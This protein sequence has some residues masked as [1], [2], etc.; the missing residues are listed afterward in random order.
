MLR[1]YT[2]QEQSSSI[3]H[4]PGLTPSPVSP[5]STMEVTRPK[6]NPKPWTMND[7]NRIIF[8]YLLRRVSGVVEKVRNNYRGMTN[9]IWDD[10][11]APRW[12]YCNISEAEAS[13]QIEILAQSRICEEHRPALIERYEWLERY[14]NQVANDWSRLVA[15]YTL[16][17]EWMRVIEV[18][19]DITRM[20]RRIELPRKLKPPKLPRPGHPSQDLRHSQQSLDRGCASARHATEDIEDPTEID[21]DSSVQVHDSTSAASNTISD[22][23]SDLTMTFPMKWI[24]MKMTPTKMTKMARWRR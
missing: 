9:R 14:T 15:M 12:Q 19:G 24:L 16:E 4:L 20:M 22:S 11:K 10:V 5:I 23:D 6:K 1:A 13:K 8:M 18:F 17:Q 2:H 21:V 3:L 7:W